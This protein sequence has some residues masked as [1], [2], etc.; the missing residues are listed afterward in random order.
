[1]MQCEAATHFHSVK[2][3]TYGSISSLLAGMFPRSSINICMNIK[4]DVKEF[5]N[6]SHS[7][8][9]LLFGSFLE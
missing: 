2:S 3:P 9:Y 6:D 8:E 4:Y 5:F 1:M 7:F